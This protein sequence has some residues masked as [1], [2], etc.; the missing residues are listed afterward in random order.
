MR[1]SGKTGGLFAWLSGSR[2]EAARLD[3]DA[4]TIIETARAVS[5]SERLRDIAIQVGNAL[6]TAHA[7]G[8]GDPAR[9]APLIDHFRTQHREARRRRDDGALT[10]LTLVIIY[11]RA[12]KI[13][14]DADPARASIDS[15]VSEWEH[16]LTDPPESRPAQ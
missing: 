12:E 2:R 5:R 11:L 7:R 15:F 9:Y 16:V 4:R 13:G 1:L 6:R 3:R 10:A 8:G 14:P